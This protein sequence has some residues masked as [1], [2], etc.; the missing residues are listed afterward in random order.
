MY[1]LD[2][3]NGSVGVHVETIYKKGDR[4]GI[5]MSKNKINNRD[6]TLT[7]GWFETFPLGRY[8]NHRDNTNTYIRTV[9]DDIVL[10]AATDLHQYSEIFVDYHWAEAISGFRNTSMFG[11]KPS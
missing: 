3:I 11:E 7:L 2:K 1:Y 10:Y 4:I 6:R 9:G 5:W 8:C